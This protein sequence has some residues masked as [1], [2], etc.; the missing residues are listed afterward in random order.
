MG[1]FS[2]NMRKWSRVIH[3]DLSFFFS[4]VIIIYALSGIFLNH[5]RDFNPNYVV[6]LKEYQAEGTYPSS[7]EAFDKSKAL[8]LL[9]PLKEEKNFT[10]HYFPNDSTLKIFIKGG[11][12]LVIDLN[13]GKGIYESLKKRPV[14]HLF[15]RLHYNPGK[16]W[17]WF[18]DFFAV[19]L[20]LITLTGLIMNKGKKGI[21]GRGGIELLVGIL[22]PLLFIL[23]N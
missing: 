23:M 18:S 7:K 14:I 16:G 12:S 5:K 2:S 21:W 10:K 1:K 22:I 9:V 8:A 20:I 6:T 17:T 19:S 3:R 15:N 4:G 11:S 13:T